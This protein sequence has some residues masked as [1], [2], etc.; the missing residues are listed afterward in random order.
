MVRT[1]RT[2]PE[3][4]KP[5]NARPLAG[6]LASFDLDMRFQRRSDQRVRRMP[7]HRAV[8][9]LPA[10]AQFPTDPAEIRREHIRDFIAGLA[11]RVCNPSHMPRP[12]LSSPHLLQLPGPRRRGRRLPDDRDAGAQGRRAAARRHDRGRVARA[13]EGV[14]R[15]SVRGLPRP[16]SDPPDSGCRLR[17]GEAARLR[18]EDLDLP[19]GTVLVL[20]RAD[21]RRSLFLG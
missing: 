10:R 1:C 12:L 15:V 20:P 16:G 21:S 7:R 9:R 8:P 17:R 18:V 6:A 2:R 11:A 14:R 3:P 13:P 19:N 4:R 5:D